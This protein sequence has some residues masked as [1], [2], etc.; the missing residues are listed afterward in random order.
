MQQISSYNRQK[1]KS[2][3][4]SKLKTYITGKEKYGQKVS[5]IPDQSKVSR[6]PRPIKK[7]S[8]IT[9]QQNSVKKGFNITIQ[10][11]TQRRNTIQSLSVPEELVSPE[12]APQ[13]EDQNVSA[14]GNRGDQNGVKESMN[15]DQKNHDH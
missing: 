10:Q 4:E 2:D 3:E 14:A 8:D 6:I 7:E 9:N 15:A 13:N 1:L 11:S 12:P 5:R